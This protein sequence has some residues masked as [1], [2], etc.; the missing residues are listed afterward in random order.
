VPRTR[1]RS[2]QQRSAALTVL[3]AVM[4]APLGVTTAVAASAAQDNAA[5]TGQAKGKKIKDQYIVTFDR[6]A[7]TAEVDSARA[8]ARGRGGKVHY[9]YK[10]AVKGFSATLSAD[11]V[12]ELKKNPNVLAV[13]PDYE[14]HASDITQTPATWGLDRIDQAALPLDNSYTYGATGAGI[15]AFVIDTG[16]RST[17]T[18]FAGRVAPGFSAVNDGNGTNDCAGHGTHVA[19]TIGGSTYGVAK[20][21]TLVPVRVLDC[22]GSGSNSGVIAGVDW[23]TQNHG[24]ASAVANMSLG[25]GAS[26]ALDN[27]IANSIASGVTYAVAAGNENANACNSSPAR[28][29]AAITVGATTNTDARSSFSNYGSCVDIFAPGSNITSSINTGDSATAVYS[30]TSMATPHV[31]GVVATYL[32]SAPNARPA[33]VVTALVNAA[34]S[35]LVTGAGTGSPNKLLR[36]VAGTVTPPP[37]PHPPPPPGNG[38]VASAPTA[39]IVATGQIG[40]STVPVKVAWPVATDPDGIGSYQLQQSTDGGGNW[41]TAVASTTATN[42]TL[43]LAAAASLTFRV[44]AT[45][46]PGTAGAYAQGSTFALALRQETGTGVSYPAG[47]WYQSAVTGASGGYVGQSTSTGAKVR[48]TFTGTQVSWVGTKGANRGR[49]EVF[50]DGVSRGVVDQYSSSTQART[51]LF[52]T[53][54]GAGSHTLEVRALHTKSS[55]SSGYTVDDDAFVTVG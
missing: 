8:S 22:N 32:Q 53:T 3:V 47:S 46:V 10:R 9:N 4:L 21:V 7:T 13:E 43:N 18:Q 50:V 55:A 20:G 16:I 26:T 17:H 33:D 39:T 5:V 19:G 51:I 14:V 11:A 40:A 29:P 30:G 36:T 23:V 25:G 41:T 6:T 12:T 34:T 1:L 35:N 38:P 31:A 37:P 44:R 42:V 54:L 2:T 45:D 28:L 52:N 49:A 24:T 27:A 15:K 48:L